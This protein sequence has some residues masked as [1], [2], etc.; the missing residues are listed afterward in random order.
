MQGKSVV[1]NLF[2]FILGLVVSYKAFLPEKYQAWASVV[3]IAVSALLSN[4]FTN[5]Q[6][7]R[8]WDKTVLIVSIAGI[9]V[10]LFNALSDNAILPTM[11]TTYVVIAV[12]TFINVFF[13]NYNDGGPG[14]V[15]SV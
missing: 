13:K 9:I 14:K 2:T 12:N 15:A 11:Y 10:Q 1:F 7:I 3:A 8:H 4:F 5:G 6:F